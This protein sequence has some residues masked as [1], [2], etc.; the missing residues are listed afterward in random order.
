MR[1]WIRL[2]RG[3][4][5]GYEFVMLPGGHRGSRKN[6]IKVPE[7]TKLRVVWEDEVHECETFNIAAPAGVVHDHGKPCPY[8][9]NPDIPY[10]FVGKRPRKLTELDVS[11]DDLYEALNP[12]EKPCPICGTI[13]RFAHEGGDAYA[14][15][16]PSPPGTI[17]LSCRCSMQ[18]SVWERKE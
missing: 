2:E 17:T 9:G 15:T 16:S 12:V 7:G 4:D 13:S 8:A 14:A 18:R 1:E 10:V 6:E 5:W 11:K 3:N